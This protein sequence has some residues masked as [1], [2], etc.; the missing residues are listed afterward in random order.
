MAST[1]VVY[2]CWSNI[3]IVYLVPYL[4]HQT[5]IDRLGH[6]LTLTVPKHCYHLFKKNQSDV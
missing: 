5:Q 1:W 3:L 6:K 2:F 4:Y